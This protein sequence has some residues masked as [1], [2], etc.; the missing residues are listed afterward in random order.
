M[1]NKKTL[2]PD[3]SRTQSASCRAVWKQLTAETF[4]NRRPADRV[5][6]AIMRG[7]REFGSRDRRFISETVFGFFRFWGWLRLLPPPEKAAAL[8][9]SGA[10]ELTAIEESKLLLGAALLA[11]LPGPLPEAAKFWADHLRVAVPAVWDISAAG[12]L[13]HAPDGWGDPAK[14]LP[15][16]AAAHITPQLDCGRL[17]ESLAVRPFLWLRVQDGDPGKLAAELA[18][19]GLSAH[20]HPALPEALAVTGGVNVYTLESFRS[21]RF[22]VQD[23][24]SQ[25]IGL[26]CAPRAGER[27]WDCCAGAGGKSLELASLMQRKGTVVATDIRSYKLDDLRKR[28]RRAGF[29]N[30]ETRPWDGGRPRHA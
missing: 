9:N 24:A 4:G 8:E 27:W 7:H 26:V 10:A 23:L 16:W 18:A 28:A 20:A 21:G 29:P 22:E 14:M 1:D 30:I 19:A 12:K 11:H 17:L 3:K 6:A 13:L 5:L 2:S 15:G 25:L